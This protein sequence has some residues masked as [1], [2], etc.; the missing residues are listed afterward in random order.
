MLKLF[1]NRFFISLIIVFFIGFFT[2]KVNYIYLLGLIATTLIGLFLLKF[3]KKNYEEFFIKFFDKNNKKI[4]FTFFYYLILSTI[5]FI[6]LIY[7]FDII[8]LLNDNTHTFG[9][10]GDF[11]GG[12]LNPLLMFITFL[13]ILFT[14]LI[15][16]KEFKLGR[17]EAKKTANSLNTQAIENTFFNL[18]NL[19][20]NNINNIKLDLKNLN[21]D[22]KNELYE[23]IK[24]LTKSFLL[25]IN[26]PLIY[27]KDN[28]EDFDL[29]FRGMDCFEI[30][31]E[32]LSSESLKNPI[33]AYKHIQDNH[34]YIFGHYFRNLY[35]IL[36][37]IDSYDNKIMNSKEKNKYIR[38]LRAQL[39]TSELTLLFLNCLD[40][41][42][43]SGQFKEYLIKY[44]L[45][46]HIQI[47]TI[48]VD[49]TLKYE[50]SNKISIDKKY[51]LE[52]VDK[53][54][55]KSAFGTNKIIESILL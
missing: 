41:I 53:D 26:Y 21:I 15:Q 3:F 54:N 33:D 39:S 55:N 5:I 37:I 36:L 28:K 14:I 13:A 9:T 50:F 48:S 11:A 47:R 12:V 22:H 34:N 16:I 20:H 23:K 8:K 24:K 1:C 43:D 19:H 49:S 4:I 38:I 52:Y 27:E 30:I 31:I 25:N 46:E 51:I 10:F 18:I 42:C 45:L 32:Y 7:T 35:Q 2:L 44:S 40:G 6:I 29:I 17:K